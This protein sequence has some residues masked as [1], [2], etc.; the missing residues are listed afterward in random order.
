MG[1]PGENYADAE[2]PAAFWSPLVVRNR[3]VAVKY[4][5]V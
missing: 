5:R 2:L 4:A 1:I 3:I